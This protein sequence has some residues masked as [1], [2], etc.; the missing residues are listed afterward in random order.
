VRRGDWKLI[1]IDGREKLYNLATDPGET[2]NLVAS[3][4]EADLLRPMLPKAGARGE[5]IAPPPRAERTALEVLGYI[6]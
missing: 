4:P 2:T 3:Q 1:D 6:E 5:T